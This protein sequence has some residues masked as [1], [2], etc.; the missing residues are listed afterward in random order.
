MEPVKRSSAAPKS[1]LVF[2]SAGERSNL[3]RWTRGGRNFDLWIT[4]YGTQ[5]GQYKELADFYNV[6]KGSKFQNLKFAYDSWPEHFKVYEAILVMD[7]DVL[8]DSKGIERLFDIRRQED[9]WILQPAFD[10]RGKVSWPITK[11]NPLCRLRFTNFVEMTCP[12]FRQDKLAQFMAIY[13]PVLVGHGMD[14]WFLHSM[15]PDLKRRVAVVD[16]IVCVNPH[17]R[18]KGRVREI[19]RLQPTPE[20]IKIWEELKSKHGIKGKEQGFVEF[21]R[22]ARPL[23]EAIW[24]TLK[25]SVVRVWVTV[26]WVAWWLREWL[27]RR[28]RSP[29]TA[30]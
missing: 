26:R 19:D 23:R 6:R 15:G 3:Y 22:I 11:V 13:D 7:D 27:Y 12:L 20:R 5:E 21:D 29:R 2:T 14:W 9:L 16:E 24:P 1:Y 10:P 25:Y 4:Y 28:L 17:D 30:G 18:T 8:I